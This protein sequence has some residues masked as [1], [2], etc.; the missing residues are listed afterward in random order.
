MCEIKKINL[1]KNRQQKIVDL[2][3][4]SSTLSS[5]PREYVSSTGLTLSDIQD[6]I[7]KISKCAS[8]IE[9]KESFIEKEHSFEQVMSV[10]AANFC[11]QHVICPIC[12]DRM[13]AR[14][15]A[16]FNDPIKNQASLVKSGS[17]HAYLLT[18]TIADG[19]SLS[20]RLEHLKESKKAFRKMGQVRQGDRSKG[21]AGK[22]RAAVSTF[23]I[24]RGKNSK[25]WHVHCHDLVFTDAPL[26]YQVYD[27]EIKKQLHN[28]YGKHIPADILNDSALQRVKFQGSTVATS[29]ISS[30]W[31]RATGG[32]SMS[33]S[34]DKIR[35]IPKNAHGKKKRMFQKMS[36]EDSVAYQAKEVLKYISKPSELN[37]NDSIIILNETF[38]KRMVATYGEFRG[39]TTD[40]YNDEKD[41][42]DSNYV[43]VWK[44]GKYT[45]AQP[46]E[47]RS[48][49]DD[50]LE[51]EARQKTGTA[52]GD[53]RRRRRILID[54]RETIKTDLPIMLDDLKMSFKQKV[55]LIWRKF[56]YAQSNEIAIKNAKCDKYSAIIALNGYYLPG[57]TSQDIYSN[58]F[59]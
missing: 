29:K 18:Y 42:D 37:I 20:E 53:Y 4:S 27:A 14:R 49:S 45:D 47:V 26:D 19:D 32:D 39:V 24:K 25:Q 30:E 31:F 59:A 36:F 22:I 51:T 10:A 3:S 9:L 54:Q 8:I 56:R 46:G 48:I 28:R 5:I 41:P 11:K 40:D 55:A 2:L 50:P 23:E 57:S 52:L 16:K 13:Q 6:K 7:E 35:H 58:A 43:M 17:R 38:N 33:I 1:L 15:R 44:D 34:V 21:E 12:A